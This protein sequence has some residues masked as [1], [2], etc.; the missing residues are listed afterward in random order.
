MNKQTE[1]QGHL[2]HPIA[3]TKRIGTRSEI[4]ADI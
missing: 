1:H 4:Y 2:M 3:R